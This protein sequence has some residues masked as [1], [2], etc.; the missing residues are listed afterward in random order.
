MLIFITIVV[1]VSAIW[2]IWRLYSNRR[3]LP[4]PSWLSGIIELDNPL[5]PVHKVQSIITD[6]ELSE[7]MNVLDVGCGP[8]RVMLP[9]AQKVGP[10]GHV[11][12]VD[13]QLGMIQKARN[14]AQLLELTNIDFIHGEI[15]KVKLEKNY[16]DRA[17]L[18]AVLGEIPASDRQAALMQ[19]FNALKPDGIASITEIIF[20]PHFQRRQK[21][22]DLM[23]D[24]GFVQKKSLGRWFAYT[25]QFKK[26][27]Y[28]KF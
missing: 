22:I 6:L 17:I 1:L 14:K 5:A 4:C 16:Y 27:T 13:V 11:T 26:G 10:S 15:G 2:F 12:S 8:G 28:S 21:V 9:I 25:I 7:G 18:V 20:D 3:L 23:L 24:A 19:I